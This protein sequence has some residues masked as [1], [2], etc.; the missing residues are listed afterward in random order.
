MNKRSRRFQPIQRLARHGE[1]QAI[2][3]LGLAQTA[4][5][6]QEQRL[7]D[8][9]SYRDEYAQQF[10]QSGKSGLDGRQ[11]QSYQS[12]LNQLSL[13]IEQQKLKISQAQ[14]HCD[15]RRHDWQQRHQHSEALDSAVKRIRTQEQRIERRQEQ[16]N[17]DEHTMRA[18]K[19]SR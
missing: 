11:L 3:Q 15:E 1:D 6:D 16:R 10:H 4:L 2:Q 19:P 12:F 8:L 18:H 5:S 14:Q 9:I 17:S 13:A 7:L